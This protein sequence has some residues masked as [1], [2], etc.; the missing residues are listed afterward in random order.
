VATSA[1]SFAAM[2]A[3]RSFLETLPTL[4]SGHSGTISTR[5][6]SLYVSV[7]RE[8]ERRAR[9]VRRLHGR[10]DTGVVH[11]RER[12]HHDGARS[13]CHVSAQRRAL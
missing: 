12:V 7:R 1:W 8:D 2:S 5:S 4:V 6:G 10:G 13:P 11:D 9:Q 3:R